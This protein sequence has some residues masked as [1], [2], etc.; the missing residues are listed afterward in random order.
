MI[1]TAGLADG[2]VLPSWLSYDPDTR[3]FDG[4]PPATF[5][6]ELQILIT[7]S[8][9]VASTSTT[10]SLTVTGINDGGP[11]T[12]T[13]T[14]GRDVLIGTSSNDVIDGLGDTDWL[15]G[16]D[17]DDIFLAS[18]NA[19]FDTYL[20]G[21]G[22]DTIRGSSGDD[23]IGIAGRTDL[24]TG[25]EAIDG[26]DGFD[27]VRLTGAANSLDLSL[28]TLTSI[29]LIDAGGG[30]DMVIG[31]AGDDVIMGGRGADVL[32]GGA[33]ND[34]FLFTGRSGRDD[35]DGGDGFDTI[36]GSSNDDVLRLENGSANLVS[37][38]ALVFSDGFDKIRLGPGDDMLD[39]SRL[40]VSGLEQIEGGAGNDRIVASSADETIVGGAGQDIFVFQDNFGHDTI[41]DFRLSRG[42]TRPSDKIDLSNLGFATFGNILANAGQIGFDTVISDPDSGSTLTLSKIRLSDLHAD[43]FIL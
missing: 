15:D 1:Y 19:G 31:S 16:G 6:G 38:E 30:I 10:F 25:I 27:I 43:D 12:I 36:I 8:D 5:T 41:A 3:T 32:F 23:I 35:Y 37:I 33:G 2:G 29:E 42:G 26:G 21:D 7:A 28:I 4:I 9:S 34:T 11:T 20:G 39:L 14:S 24:L 18:G 22:F 13:G 40:A 17:G